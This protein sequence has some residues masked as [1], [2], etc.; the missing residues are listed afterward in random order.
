MLGKYA[1]RV[2]TLAERERD[3]CRRT[4]QGLILLPR[5]HPFVSRGPVASTICAISSL[6][7]AKGLI[8]EPDVIQAEFS[9]PLPCSLATGE[10]PDYARRQTSDSGSDSSASRLGQGAAS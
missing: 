7:Q 6:P 8:T 2:P 5:K 3:S 9:S 10:L 4:E 1:V